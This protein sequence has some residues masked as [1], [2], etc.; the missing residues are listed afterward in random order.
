MTDIFDERRKGLEQDYFNRKNK[1]ALDKLRAARLEEA[2]ARGEEAATMTCP[3]CDGRL[4]EVTYEDVRIDRCDK[5]QGIWLDS[6]ELEQLVNQEGGPGRWLKVLWP[7]RVG[8]Q[9]M[10]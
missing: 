4:H 8:G 2:R 1:E 10:E 3:R 7:G 9:G 6:G 5:C